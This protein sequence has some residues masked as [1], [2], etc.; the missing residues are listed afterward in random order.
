MALEIAQEIVKDGSYKGA[1]AGAGKMQAVVKACTFD[2]Y[3][4]EKA[5]AGVYVGEYLLANKAN[6]TEQPPKESTCSQVGV[7]RLVMPLQPLIH[8]KHGVLRFK[9]NKIVRYLLDNG[10]IDM[11]KLAMQGFDDS[12]SEQFAQLI[13][14]S[15][16][17]FAELSY[18]KEIDY[19]M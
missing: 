13:G 7:E 16:S 10:G 6:S 4:D 18:V 9:E 3:W 1:I 17:G 8:D 19:E 15:L 14:Y 5:T 11:N 2:E 12:D